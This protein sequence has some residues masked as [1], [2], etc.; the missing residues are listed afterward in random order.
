MAKVASAEGDYG[1]PGSR[2]LGLLAF[3]L[4]LEM[5]LVDLQNY[6]ILGNT[7]RSHGANSGL[8]LV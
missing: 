7:R 5:R 2:G 1:V 3:K 4:S 6:L 8:S